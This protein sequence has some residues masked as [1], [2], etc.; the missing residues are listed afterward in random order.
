MFIDLLPL[1]NSRC[2]D[3]PDNRHLVSQ[4]VGLE[5]RTS[6]GGRDVIDHVPLAHNDIAVAVAGAALAAWKIRGGTDWLGNEHHPKV[7]LGHSSVDRRGNP[8]R[9]IPLYRAASSSER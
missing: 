9:V 3:L 2:I 6:R 4:L 1:I 7:I 8:G 5:R